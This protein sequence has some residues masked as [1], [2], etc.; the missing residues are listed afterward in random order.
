MLNLRKDLTKASWY[1]RVWIKGKIGLA[2]KNKIIRKQR[3]LIGSPKVCQTS[4]E[5][6]FCLRLILS[7]CNLQVC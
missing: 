6:L 2:M 1:D 4:L 5:S 3:G 7:T